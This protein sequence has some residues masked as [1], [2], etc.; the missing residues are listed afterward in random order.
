[1]NRWWRG[2]VALTIASCSG[3][4]APDP[5]AAQGDLSITEARRIDATTADLSSIGSML[6]ASNGDVLVTQM[7]DN[8]IRVFPPSGVSR[9]IGRDGEGPGEFRRLTRAGWIGDSI[10]TLDPDLSRVTIFDANYELVRSFPM[11][12]A[13]KTETGDSVPVEMYVQAVLPGE[14]LRAIAFVPRGIAPPAWASDVDSGSTHYVR[15]AEDGR[16]L[17]RILLS[18]PD[19]CRVNYAI[20][21][22]GYGTASYPFCA[23]PVS[24]DWSATA[25]MAIAV[26]GEAGTSTTPV[27]VI[28]L[29]PTGDTLMQR[30]LEFENLPVTEAAADSQAA[31]LAAIMASRPQHIRDAMPKLPAASTWP[32]VRS[33]VLGTDGT[34]W[35]EIEELTPAHRWQMLST[36]GEVIGSV[37]LPANFAL[38]VA[39]RTIIWGLETD[40]DDLESVVAYRVD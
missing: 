34:V 15:V 9:T 2:A 24:T 20:G 25:G 6:V 4:E 21:S 16:H 29:S 3:S 39:S 12:I 33:L 40:E 32:P 35:L 37:D 8:V 10:W 5:E 26:A 38:R 28:V 22:G 14:A 31:R 7:E 27:Q 1:M 11:P 17:G 13:I 18:P 19:H 23:S 36:K 30:T